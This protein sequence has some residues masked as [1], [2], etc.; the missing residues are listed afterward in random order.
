MNFNLEEGDTFDI[1]LSRI[2]TTHPKIISLCEGKISFH[3]TP[4][5]NL[6]YVGNYYPRSSN[7]LPVYIFELDG[8]EILFF[9]CEKIRS[10]IP[11]NVIVYEDHQMP[12]PYQ[13]QVLCDGFWKSFRKNIGYLTIEEI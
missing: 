7:C 11:K 13:I 12:L 10:L 8:K 3:D 1:V 5:E 4:P 6:S 2:Q 9:G